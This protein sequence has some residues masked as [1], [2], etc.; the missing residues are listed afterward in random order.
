MIP[1]RPCAAQAEHHPLSRS[2]PLLNPCPLVAQTERPPLLE[3]QRVTVRTARTLGISTIKASGGRGCPSNNGAAWTWRKYFLLAEHHLPAGSHEA[4]ELSGGRSAS[5]HQ[6]KKK[7]AFPQ[8]TEANPRAT[9][10]LIKT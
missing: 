4:Y 1:Y 3:L 6:K 8:M 10:W 5:L 9:T 2:P 7:P